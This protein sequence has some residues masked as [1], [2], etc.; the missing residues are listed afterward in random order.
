M[1]RRGTPVL[2]AAA[3]A[4]LGVAGCGSPS[5]D[6]FVVHRAGSTPGARL[7]MLV[8]DGG[9]VRCNDGE[10]HDITSDDLILAR[11]IARELNGKDDAHP[12][13]AVDSVRLAPGPGSILRYEIRSEKGRV[14]FADTSA[15]Q[16]AVFF[17]AAKFVRDMARRVC[18][19]PR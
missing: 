12:G 19:L 5:A 2:L 17:Q 1:R 4:A 10:A 18:G 8:G 15:G 14:A 9:T 7:T 16:P 3:A 13:P 6:L 11:K